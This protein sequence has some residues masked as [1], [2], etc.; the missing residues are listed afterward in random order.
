[1]P[2]FNIIQAV[3]DALKI[4]MRR[5][6]RVVA[7]GEDVGKFGGVFRATSGLYE[8]FGADRV[9]DT[10]LAAPGIIGSAIGMALYGLRP[11][12][13]MQFADL[14]Y[15]TYDQIVKEQA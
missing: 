15:P 9:I 8:E 12:P 2:V 14:I 1:M 3:N 7:L 13:E 11:V 5:D 4:E 6:D 10:P